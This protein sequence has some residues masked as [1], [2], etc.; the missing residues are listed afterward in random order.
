MRAFLGLGVWRWVVGNVIPFKMRIGWDFSDEPWKSYGKRWA[1]ENN[2]CCNSLC[3]IADTIIKTSM[4]WLNWVFNWLSPFLKSSRWRS[5]ACMYP[6]QPDMNLYLAQ[7]PTKLFHNW[8]LNMWQEEFKSIT[9]KR[10]PS[11]NKNLQLWVPVMNAWI[12]MM[13]MSGCN[14]ML[15]HFQGTHMLLNLI[16]NQ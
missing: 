15:D 3:S 14:A 10:K 11:L 8:S 5:K 2:P 12:C 7:Y 13:C 9:L 6:E 1:E 4:T 16:L